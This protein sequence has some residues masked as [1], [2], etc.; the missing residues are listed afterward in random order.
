MKHPKIRR[1]WSGEST[2]LYVYYLKGELNVAHPF[3]GPEKLNN[4]DEVNDRGIECGAQTR[5]YTGMGP[6]L[7]GGYDR[8]NGE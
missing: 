2:L 3:P 5:H 8:G 6:T 4:H 1:P 7:D